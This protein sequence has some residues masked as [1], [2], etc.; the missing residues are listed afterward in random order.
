[1][2]STKDWFKAS[3]S[4][5]IHLPAAENDRAAGDA[6]PPIAPSHYPA[7]ISVLVPIRSLGPTYRQRIATHLL[8]LEPRDRYLRFGYAATDAQIESY[9]AKLNFERD[10]IFGVYNRHLELVAMA[11]LAFSE[12]TA[13]RPCAEFGVS[14]LAKARGQGLGARLFDRATLHARNAGVD[15]MLIYALS[16]N[17]AMLRIAAKAGATIERDGS[18]SEALLQLPPAN[19]DSRFSELFEQQWAEMDYQIKK[20]AQYMMD[21]LAGVQ[22]VRQGVRQ[23]RHH[24]SP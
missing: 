1:M 9:V 23:A 8:A 11:H 7:K 22:E 16:E 13:S 3:W 21:F 4:N 2:I 6:C 10:E 12:K 17:T 15:L 14:V 18:E 5:G 24:S 20:Q 19:F